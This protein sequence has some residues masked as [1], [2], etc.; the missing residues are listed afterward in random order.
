MEITGP[1]AAPLR[2]MSVEQDQILAALGLG[3]I[4]IGCV[5]VADFVR[6]AR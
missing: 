6:R 3:M 4:A 2:F 1:I 5:K